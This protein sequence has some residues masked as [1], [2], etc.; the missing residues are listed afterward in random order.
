MYDNRNLIPKNG[1]DHIFTRLELL[2]EN[3]IPVS[4]ESYK[5]K[6]LQ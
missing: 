2:L 1:G 3:L 5:W 4:F 6:I